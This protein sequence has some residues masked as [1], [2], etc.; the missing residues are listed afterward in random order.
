M[1]TEAGRPMVARWAARIALVLL[2]VGPACRKEPEPAANVAAPPTPA[3]LAGSQATSQK[4]LAKAVSAA[5][6]HPENK[7]ASTAEKAVPILPP[8]PKPEAA[9]GEVPAEQL[10]QWYCAACHSLELVES[11]RLSRADWEWVMED[12]VTKYGGSW[13]TADEQAGIIDYLVE[14]HGPKTP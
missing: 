10:Y 14:H 13:I 3:E 6:T 5:A 2:A 4:P 1:T 8:T 9:S 7:P 12:M 11:Q